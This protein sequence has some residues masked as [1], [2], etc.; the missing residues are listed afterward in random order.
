M[1][2]DA[3][4][5]LGAFG[6]TRASR[7][8]TVPSSLVF[9]DLDLHSEDQQADSVAYLTKQIV[10]SPPGFFLQASHVL[11]RW[12]G[13]CWDSD[14]SIEERNTFQE[15]VA[16]Q[17]TAI[18][19][20][21]LERT[22]RRAMVGFVAFPLGEDAAVTW[23]EDDGNVGEEQSLLARARRIE[24][25]TLLLAGKGIW[26]PTGYHYSLPSGEHSSTFIRLANAFKDRRDA[27]ALATWLYRELR[28][29]LAIIADTPTL[30]PLVSAIELAAC[31]NGLGSP[32]VVMLTDYASNH[33]EV[34]RAVRD[35]TGADHILGLISVSSTG[36]T[37]RRIDAA[38]SRIPSSVGSIEQPQYGL[39]TLVTRGS[40]V[41][42]TLEVGERNLRPWLGIEDAGELF[43][44]KD[45]CYICSGPESSQV[46]G[47]DPRSFE[48]MVLPRPD[49]L[50]P[51]VIL[52]SKQR[53][54]WQYYDRTLGVGI[55]AKPHSSTRQ[56]RSNH[57]RLAVRCYPHWL[58]DESL[59]IEDEGEATGKSM[60]TQFCCE[61]TERV[62][63]IAKD[64]DKN[65]PS[66]NPSFR[67]D[68]IGAIVTTEDDK[69]A[70]GF[71]QFVTA[72][73]SGFGQDPLPVIT[74]KRPYVDMDSLREE[75]DDK[76]NDGKANILVLTL[77]AIT[78]TSMQ[79][80]LLGIHSQLPKIQN[81]T[82][83]QIAGLVMHARFEDTREWEV[84]RNAY[85]RLYGIWETP[86]P[87]SSPFDDEATLLAQ[88][89]PVEAYEQAQSFYRDRLSFLNGMDPS[90]ES[91]VRAENPDVDPWA[92]FWGMPLSNAG[93][94]SR[95]KD[96]PRL[97]P[98][99]LYGHRLRGTSI[100]ATVGSAVQIARFKSPT[101]SAPALQQFEMP[102]ILRSYFDAPIVASI[103][104]WV[105]PHEV[106]WGDRPEDAVNVL[107]E[108]FARADPDDLKVLLPEYLLAAA[109]GKVSK[110]GSEWLV[111]VASHYVWCWENSIPVADKCEP[112]TDSEI[113]PV[114]L[115]LALMQSNSST[116][117][118]HFGDARDQLKK[119]SEVLDAWQKEKIPYKSLATAHLLRAL[120]TF[121]ES[122]S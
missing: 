27:S 117:G 70:I 55:H 90:W 82:N 83:I 112:W 86:L 98:G 45:V 43:A 4:L 8:P 73:S 23:A 77:G 31:K 97:R 62:K 74:A 53:T 2:Q 46:I 52:A 116:S 104:R 118:T 14:A 101:K 65:K 26:R 28:N 34:E 47:I 107:A 56:L 24:L 87:L 25:N 42:E 119:A 79:Q 15:R 120:N 16:N 67:S 49:L 76:T 21:L 54:L 85:T 3:Y 48:P 37:A 44:S 78:G 18:Q 89:T 40:A 71:D 30:L 72:V 10:K 114:Q 19:E 88:F 36:A 63:E 113:G 68:E 108:S 13:E 95:G 5:R 106:W 1:E 12:P 94:A 81:G 20:L 58:I 9:I 7:V 38:L 32:S 41:A 110:S 122:H 57:A 39:E 50:T 91:R 80:I 92:V 109:L 75:L 17:A 6:P 103:L 93:G 66:S 96:H 51:S 102:A 99:S 69:S 59:Y 84:L 121:H 61:V 11:L 33:F 105:N 111:A 22:A 100:F 29:G 115:G 60:F 64:I 35:V